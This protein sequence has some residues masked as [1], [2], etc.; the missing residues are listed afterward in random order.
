MWGIWPHAEQLRGG[1]DVDVAGPG[2]GGI[3]DVAAGGRAVEE[4]PGERS[5][6]SPRRRAVE[7]E[8]TGIRGK[9]SGQCGAGGVLA[10]L[11]RLGRWLLLTV[12]VGAA[13][14]VI[15]RHLVLTHLDEQIRVRVEGLFAAHYR[16]MVVQIEAARRVEGK[17]IEVRGFSLRSRAADAS[18]ELVHVDEL[19]LACRTD[20]RQLL[21]GNLH[22]R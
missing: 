12:L 18:D 8:L 16:D 1:G 14:G 2:G 11:S 19:F 17:G 20:L 21:S 10:R 4:R 3:R 6:G 15:C 22:L 9:E 13:G 7:R 5:G